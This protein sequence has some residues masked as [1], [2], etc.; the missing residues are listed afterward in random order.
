MDMAE[1]YVVTAGTGAYLVRDGPHKPKKPAFG[2]LLDAHMAKYKILVVDYEP[3]GIQQLAAPL[4]NAGYEVTI[5]KDGVSAIQAFNT[6][7]PD[8]VVTEAM[9]PKKN[10][11]DLCQELKKT[12]RGAKT[13]ILIVSGVYKGRKYRTQALHHYGCNEYLE[14]PIPADTLLAA[15]TRHLDAAA[16]AAAGSVPQ[17]TTKPPA[18]TAPASDVEAEIVSRIDELIPG[19]KSSKS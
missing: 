9:L 10:G 6:V 8:L 19:D 2:H 4:Q 17:T 3:R 14:K 13:P 15:V 12:P 11:F 5:E 7:E 18:S 1:G 16:A